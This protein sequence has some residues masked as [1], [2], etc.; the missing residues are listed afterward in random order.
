MNMYLKI[1]KAKDGDNEAL[2]EIIKT[3]E[4]FTNIQMKKYG[5]SDIESCYSEVVWK[6]YQ[7]IVNYKVISF[8]S[9]RKIA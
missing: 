6:I 3:Y 4:I 8:E 1:L 7:S 2:K 5:I 9:N